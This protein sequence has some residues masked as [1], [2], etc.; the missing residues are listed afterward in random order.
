MVVRGEAGRRTMLQAH[1]DRIHRRARESAEAADALSEGRLVGEPN[2]E[3]ARRGAA[4]ADL[5]RLP[6]RVEAP[7]AE[8]G[9]QAAIAKQRL[10]TVA[11]G[12]RGLDREAEQMQI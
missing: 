7:C 2:A 12:R 1:L 10:E 8:R 3:R 11:Q 9:E 5:D 4:P 6:R